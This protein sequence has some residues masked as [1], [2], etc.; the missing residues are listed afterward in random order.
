M[1]CTGPVRP[2][3]HWKFD[4]ITESNFIVVMSQIREQLVY[5]FQLVENSKKLVKPGAKGRWLR[6]LKWQGLDLARPLKLPEGVQTSAQEHQGATEGQTQA[7]MGSNLQVRD[8]KATGCSCL[9]MGP[10]LATLKIPATILPT[11]SVGESS[12]ASEPSPNAISSEKPFLTCRSRC[13]RAL[14]R[15]SV[16]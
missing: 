8:S 2:K 16:P 10:L 4:L 13:H 6:H 9:H 7:L 5:K 12:H 11:P 3:W 1:D 15:A 14:H